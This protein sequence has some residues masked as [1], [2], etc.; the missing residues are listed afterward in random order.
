MRLRR[1]WWDPRRDH[2]VPG[3]LQHVGD[4]HAH[5]PVVLDEKNRQDADRERL[6]GRRH[7]PGQRVDGERQGGDE[8]PSPLAGEDVPHLAGQRLARAELRQQFQPRIE[9]AALDD[10]VFRVA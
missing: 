10:R 7:L 5:R 3:I 4:V 1:R 6:A 8:L 9:P 2:D